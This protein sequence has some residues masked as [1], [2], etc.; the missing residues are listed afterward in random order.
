[1]SVWLVLIGTWALVMIVRA[2][3]AMAGAVE[4]FV[5]IPGRVLWVVVGRLLG[6]WGL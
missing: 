1:V 6:V 3:E 4:V 5:V 2:L